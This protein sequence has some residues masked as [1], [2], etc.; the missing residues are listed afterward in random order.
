VS[1]FHFEVVVMLKEGLADPQG[2]AIEDSLP[3]MGWTGVSGVRVGRHV[4]L[5]VEA[6]GEA[7]A[8]RIAD[9]VAERLLSNPVIEDYT[10][11]YRAEV[12]S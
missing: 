8:H 12:G 6:D 2:K 7:E 1:R 9:E 5:T 10:I 4:A 3:A 11:E